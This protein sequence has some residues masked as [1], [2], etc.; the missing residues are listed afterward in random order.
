[1]I[2]RMIDHFRRW[3]IWRKRSLNGP[4]HK[5]LV[6]FRVIESPTMCYVLLPEEETAMFMAVQKGIADGKTERR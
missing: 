1:M 2:N 4:L 3:N 6:L 5:L